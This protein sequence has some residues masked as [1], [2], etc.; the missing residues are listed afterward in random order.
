MK[1]LIINHEYP[2]VG[3]GGGVF[4]RDLAQQW[5]KLGHKVDV[6]TSNARGLK[7]KERIG[8]VNIYRIFAGW[9]SDFQKARFLN[10]FLFMVNGSF[11]SSWLFLKKRYDLVNTHFAVPS[12]PI[13]W[14][15]QTIFRS[16]N[17]LTLH[18]AD[19]YDPSRLMSGHRFFLIRW[20]VAML[21]NK[22]T[23]TIASTREIKNRANQYFKIRKN[24]KIIP[25]GFN[26]SSAPVNSLNPPKNYESGGP[27]KL[28]TTSRLVK[29]K[30]LPLLLQAIAQL[31][32]QVSLTIIGAGPEEKNLK[33][34]I[35]TLGLKNQ[36][37]FLGSVN[38]NLKYR[39]LAAAHLYISTATH[40]GFGLTFLEAMHC[41]LPVIASDSGGQTYFLKDK[42]NGRFFKSQD[43][44]DLV[45]KI[46]FFLKNP[47]VIPEYGQNNQKESRNFHI[48]KI[49]KKYLSLKI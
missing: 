6:I 24:I 36:I 48:E 1:I 18:G 41:G 19:I 23:C 45:S 8:G 27:L 14:I 31:K 34:K 29:R 7:N 47:A 30:N 3:G 9:R 10:L 16:P 15:I 21:I 44:S 40:E 4:C 32:K 26:P 39:E 22:S 37:K 11:F 46:N 43:L 35:K 28:I 25:L 2:P 49:A 5:A 42:F 17:I 38:E 33:Q 13:G 12:G 20:A